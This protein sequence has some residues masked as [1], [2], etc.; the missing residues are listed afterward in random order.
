[1]PDVSRLLPDTQRQ[2]IEASLAE[3]GS[4]TA[5]RLVVVVAGRSGRYERVEDVAGLMLG[6]L[7]AALTW[8]V[9]P[10]APV[11]GD[12]WAGYTAGAKLGMMAVTLLVGFGLGAK[13]VSVMPALRRV[14]TP[15]RRMRAQVATAA[16]EAFHDRRVVGPGDGPR[17]LIYVSLYERRASVLADEFCLSVMEQSDLDTLCRDLVTLL[18]DTDTADAVSQAVRR[19]AEMLAD[20]D[21]LRDGANALVVR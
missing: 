15:T 20:L 17:L 18:R 6:L 11:G 2:R 21:A 7:A 10:D 5:A 19:A 13:A 12:S 14:F 3:A 1:M 4:V 9:V 8:L 16:A